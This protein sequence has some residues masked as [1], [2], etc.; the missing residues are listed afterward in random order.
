MYVQF[1]AETAEEQARLRGEAES[2]KDMVRTTLLASD[3]EVK[4][5][6]WEQ[7]LKKTYYSP[8]SNV[9]Y[10]PRRVEK[11]LLL[12]LNLCEIDFVDLV[13]LFDV[14]RGVYIMSHAGPHRP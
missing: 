12:L 10:G 1:R 11:M 5:L 3:T 6:R 14:L 2:V 9:L 8:L 7:P 13:G 4:A